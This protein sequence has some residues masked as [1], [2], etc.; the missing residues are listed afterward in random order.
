M[1]IVNGLSIDL[2]EYYHAENIKNYFPANSPSR[3]EE[4]TIKILNFLESKNIQAT[5]FVLGQVAAAH[6]ELIKI[7]ATSKHEI[8]S[9]GFNHQLVYTQSPEEFREDIIRSKKLLE[10]ITGQAVLGYRAPNFSIT[11]PVSWAFDL[12]AQAGYKYDSSVYPIYH[13]RYSNLRKPRFP[14]IHLN[15]GLLEIPLATTQL[16]LGQ[17]NF[18]LPIAGGA[19]W[20]LLPLCYSKWGLARLNQL[21]QKTAFTYFHPWELDPKQPK[22]LGLK[23]ST[24]IRH[25]AGQASFLKKLDRLTTKFQF[26]T[27]AKLISEL[28]L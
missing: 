20:R 1:K 3:V 8:A 27:Y 18:N 17:K 4:S 10:D 21:E 24:K 22:A 11:E 15:N 16:S 14:Y 12:I 2:E 28:K 19:Y 25:Y 7:I 13:P 5:F 23:L 6:P 9:H 26:T